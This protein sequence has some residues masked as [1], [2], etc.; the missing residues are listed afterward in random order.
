MPYSNI[1]ITFTNDTNIPVQVSTFLAPINGISSQKNI[2]VQSNTTVSLDSCTGEW[3]VNTFI[4][5]NINIQK[6]IKNEYPY[7]FDIGKFRNKPSASGHYS[8]IYHD[9]FHLF[10]QNGTI[11]LQLCSH[12]K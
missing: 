5:D 6:L 7:G 9:D 11:T 2:I 8:W 4:Y 12:N 1:T 3:D 10:Y